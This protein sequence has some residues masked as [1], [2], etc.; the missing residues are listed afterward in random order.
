M[1]SKTLNKILVMC[2]AA[3]ITAACADRKSVGPDAELDALL[4]EMFPAD[5]PAAVAA[6]SIDDSIVYLR[7]FG[8]A[9]IGARI[10]AT[11][12]T[13][14]NICSISKQ[15]SAIALLKLQEQGLLSLD[16]P[17][18]K[19][20]PAFPGEF[21]NHI[22]QRQMLSHTSG[23]P[24]IRPRTQQ[25]WENY[26]SEN[27]HRRFANV[28]DYKHF[29]SEPDVLDM[30]ALVEG[31]V[32][33]PGT[34]YEYQNPTF[35]LVYYIVERLTGQP[36]AEWMEQNVFAP[37]HMESTGYFS[38]QMSMAATA[39]GYEYAG[40]RWQECD[41]GEANFFPTAAD[42]GIYTSATDFMA[43][44]KA[45]YADAIV[46]T[47]SR[48]QAHTPL[49]ATDEPNTGYGLG[50]YIEDVP[51]RPRKIYHTGDNGG[52]YTYACAIPS[53]RVS[54]LIFAAR[55]GWDRLATAARIDSILTA[56]KIL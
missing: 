29:S 3:M 4:T 35:Q 56:H 13:R 20:F 21:Y 18:S 30:F 28:D 5:G 24:D 33:E 49:I 40:G 31:P 52:F 1:V 19:F 9:D 6:V 26:A 47:A 43:W 37:A 51:G 7:A 41:Y 48:G 12:D 55:Q 23:L 25:E 46:S 45:L 15:F 11:T 16:D 10:P 14:F 27:A 42:G 8:L 38:P 44:Q 32:F 22:T 17:V 2:M 36:F 50:F 34:Q 39:H 53:R 54:Y